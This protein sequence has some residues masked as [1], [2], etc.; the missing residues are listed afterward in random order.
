VVSASG[1]SVVNMADVSPLTAALAVEES[2]ALADDF[3]RLAA[4][5]RSTAFVHRVFAAGV[6][7]IGG[8][9]VHQDLDSVRE[10]S[11]LLVTRKV[12]IGLPAAVMFAWLQRPANEHFL[13]SD[14]ASRVAVQLAPIGNV[15]LLLTNQNDRNEVIRNFLT[16]VFVGASQP[17]TRTRS[18]SSLAADVST[19]AGSGKVGFTQAYEAGASTLTGSDHAN[20]QSAAS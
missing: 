19:R 7:V 11:A 14:W 20:T 12:A 13:I 10:F 5:E 3:R 4:R 17:T 2:R 18:K 1:N 16:N 8:Y 6:V 9:L 15:T